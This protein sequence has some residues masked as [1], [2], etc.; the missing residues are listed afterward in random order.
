MKKIW[1]V[2]SNGLLGEAMQGDIGSTKAQA[3][4]ADLDS[5]VSFATLHPGITHIVNCSAYSLVDLAEENRSLA[6]Q[7]NALGPENLGRL[8]KEIGAKVVHISTDYVFPGDVLRPLHEDDFAR[9]LNYYGETKLEGE[10]RLLSVNPTSCVIRTS[11]LFGNGGKNFLAKI[12]KM[13]KE[14]EEVFLAND[15]INSPTFVEDLAGA[16]LLMLDAS[17]IYHFSNQGEAT[18]YDFGKEIFDFANK[19]GIS[20]KTQRLYDVPS[21]TFPSLCKRPV[22]SVFDTSKIEKLLRMPIRPWREALQGFLGKVL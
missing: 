19:R 14:K 13:F 1:V 9:P 8:G 10:Q 15:Q 17:G 2:G 22:Y 7:V 5:L 18:K 11:A 16:I 3:D 6:Y 4:I 12:L 20:L 21:C